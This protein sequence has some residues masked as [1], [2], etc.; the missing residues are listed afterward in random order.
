MI[1]IKAILPLLL[2]LPLISC[3]PPTSG[4]QSDVKAKELDSVKTIKVGNSPHGMWAASGFV[5]NANNADGTI[6][7]ID[8]AKDEVV[9]TIT[10]EGGT[11]NYIKAF[12]D[13]KNIL[14]LDE[15]QGNLMVFDPAQDHKLI[16]TV[17]LGDGPDKIQVS[18][19]DKMVFVSLVEE[20]K[21]VALQFDSDRSKAPVIK[22]FKVGTMLEGEEHRSINFGDGW[23]ATPNN[24]EN[25]VSLVNLTT[26]A[27][28]KLRDGN[29]PS[30][31]EIAVSSGKAQSVVVGNTASNTVTIFDINSDTKKT[32]TDVGLS[33]TDSARLEKLSRA[34]ITMAGSNEVA[35]IDYLNKSLVKKIAVGSR[36]VHIYQVEGIKAGSNEVWIGNDAGD[37]VTVIDADSL[38]V[39]ATVKVGKGHHKMAFSGSKAYV[40]SITDGTVSVIDRSKI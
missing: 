39:K 7:V 18:E 24:A 37:S 14:A 8:T 30:T 3:S 2:I 36:P 12:H 23:I 5:Y 1:K 19:D 31:V 16:Q 4:N 9:K 11:S 27:E 34:Y 15:K 22:E 35:V 32:L 25:D 28:K 10:I 26:G 6:S 38:A 20:D 29:N 40:S 17:H 21:A 13:G 33:P